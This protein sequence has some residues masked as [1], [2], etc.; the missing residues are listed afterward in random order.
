M[1]EHAQPVGLRG[2]GGGRLL[3]RAQQDAKALAVVVGGGGQLVGVELQPAQ[4]CQVRVDQIG[5]VFAPAAR[6][7]S[8]HIGFVFDQ[9]GEE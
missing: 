8:S 3:P 7:R 2:T 1:E 5:L 4:H 9:V 6:S